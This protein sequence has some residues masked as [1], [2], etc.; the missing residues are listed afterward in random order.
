MMTRMHAQS[1]G[2]PFILALKVG[3]E[4]VAGAGASMTDLDTIAAKRDLHVVS[5]DLK[6]WN[7]YR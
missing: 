6:T 1:L 4:I 5:G 7:L 3:A 2:F